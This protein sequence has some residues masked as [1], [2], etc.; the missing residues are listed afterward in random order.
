MEIF[1]NLLYHDVKIYIYIFFI[2]AFLGW[3]MESFGSIINPKVKK[4][5][6]RGFMIGPYCPVY[7]LGVVLITVLLSKYKDD[8]ITVFFLSIFICGGLEYFTSWI[9]EKLFGARWWDYSSKK[10]NING[11]V[12]LETLIPFGL[13]GTLTLC[14]INP[15]FVKCL[16][17]LPSLLFNVLAWV[18]LGIFVIDFILSFVIING[19]KNIAF[20]DCDNTEQISD[21]VKEKTEEIVD[22]ITDKVEDIAMKATSDII[23]YSRKRRVKN[24]RLK[25]NKERR[26]LAKREEQRKALVEFVENTRYQAKLL[27]Y[28]VKAEREKIENVFDEKIKLAKMMSKE[29]TDKIKDD[30]KTKSVW[31]RRLVNAYPDFELMMKKKLTIDKRE[32]K[33]KLNRQEKERKNK[34]KEEIK[35]NKNK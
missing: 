20:K 3:C 1:D 19:F 21:M 6:N 14:V 27:N 34:I 31:Y 9:L 17:M 12:C 8:P 10:F 24:L 22:D 28:K 32:L 5:V 23:R 11:R 18:L 33:K 7:G 25:R 13:F 35:E 29:K 4:F 16:F 15:F 2:W 30:L 26:L